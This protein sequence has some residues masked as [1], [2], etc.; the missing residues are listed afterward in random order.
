MQ[1]N[2]TTQPIKW[3]KWTCDQKVITRWGVRTCVYHAHR[4]SQL[5]RPMFPVHVSHVQVRSIWVVKV[6]ALEAL[7]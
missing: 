2:A 7:H 1:E 6:T 3:D 4:L 5:M